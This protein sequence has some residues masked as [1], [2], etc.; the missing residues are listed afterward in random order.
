MI[1]LLVALIV[2]G[3]VLYLVNLIPMPA[4]VKQVINVLAVLYVVLY[5]LGVLGVWHGFP[6]HLGR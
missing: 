5:A 1:D 2:L 4:W 6:Q 3:V